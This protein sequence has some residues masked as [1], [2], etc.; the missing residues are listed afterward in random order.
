M[1]STFRAQL[2]IVSTKAAE[3]TPAYLAVMKAM[4]VCRIMCA[5]EVMGLQAVGRDSKEG[6]L[7]ALGDSK[8]RD[9]C[10]EV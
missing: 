3:R 10:F 4:F 5:R 2:S 7:L 6:T 9:E 8:S 1:S